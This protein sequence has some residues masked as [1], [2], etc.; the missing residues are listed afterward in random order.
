MPSKAEMEVLHDEYLNSI[1][2]NLR[3]IADNLPGTKPPPKRSLFNPKNI[4]MCAEQGLSMESAAGIFGHAT[5]AIIHNPEMLEAYKRG[6]SKAGSLIRASL[7]DDALNK[8]IL[9]AKLHLDKV[10]NKEDNTQQVNLTVT[11][12]PLENIPTEQL[13]EFDSGEDPSN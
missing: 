10:L 8:D 12:S 9:Q 2:R 13:L 5:V 1:K 4:E 6:R 7:M 11:K 3:L